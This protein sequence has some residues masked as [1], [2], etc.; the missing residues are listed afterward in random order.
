VIKQTPIKSSERNVLVCILFVFHFD[1]SIYES[2][3]M[4][5]KE[6]K[7][8]LLLQIRGLEN[9]GHQSLK[10]LTMS[11]SVDEM[12]HVLHQLNTQIQARRKPLPAA[13]EATAI[14]HASMA[15]HYSR[16]SSSGPSE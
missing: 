5:L 1:N 4:S 11:S 9:L 12:N 3:T 13:S 7:A 2:S 16:L 6:Q 14:F 10:T 8:H 15:N